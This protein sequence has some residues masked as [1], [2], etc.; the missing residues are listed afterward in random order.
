VVGTVSLGT[1]YGRIHDVW[2]LMNPDKLA[3]WNR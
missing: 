1:A 3:A 2:I